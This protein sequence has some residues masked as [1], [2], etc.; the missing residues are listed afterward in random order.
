[1]STIV[2][3]PGGTAVLRDPSEVTARHSRPYRK[4]VLSLG[5]GRFAEII[6]ADTVRAVMSADIENDAAAI[7]KLSDE[8]N[9]TEDEAEKLERLSDALI[10]KWLASWSLPQPIP[11][12][13]D[14]VLDMP[15]KLRD[16]LAGHIGKAEAANMEEESRFNVGPAVEDPDSP[17]GASVALRPPR[18][19]TDRSTSKTSTRKRAAGSKNTSTARGTS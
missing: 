8:M 10:V 15:D 2:E 17:T 12:T 14:E 3:I 4:I 18:R 9:L 6:E 13:I 5:L 1:M 19:P 11:T 7:A 16:A